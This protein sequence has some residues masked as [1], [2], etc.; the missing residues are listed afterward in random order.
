MIFR[1]KNVYG[2]ALEEYTVEMFMLVIIVIERR[3]PVLL[4][5]E[6]FIPAWKP[7]QKT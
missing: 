6:S 3:G 7:P 1:L 4:S 5:L 2:I